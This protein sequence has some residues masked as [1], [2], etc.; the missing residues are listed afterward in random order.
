[1]KNKSLLL[2]ALITFV[3]LSCSKS[4]DKLDR[5]PFL[6]DPL[7]NLNLNLNLPE[8]NSLKFPGSSVVTGQ[9]IKGIV[10]F[11]VSETQYFAFD[12]SDPNHVPSE[13]SRM[14]VNGP[15][16]TCPCENDD[17]EY[18]IVNFGRH[19]SEP[20]TKYP[21]Q[22]YRAERNGNNIIISN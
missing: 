9:G 10:V 22:Q 21:M 4:D 18:N 1:M 7:V 8:Y 13:C 17:N 3:V 19:T 20:D 5:N 6:T 15:I 16:A 11:C 14:E 2:L 12:L